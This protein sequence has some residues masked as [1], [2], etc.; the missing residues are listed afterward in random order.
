MKKKVNVNVTVIIEY[1]WM[2]LNK[3]DSKY[4]LGPKYAKMLNMEKFCT[5]QG[6]QYGNITQHSEYATVCL[7]RVLGIYRVLNI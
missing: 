3:H 1:V 5:W 7:D 4:A 2:C 6:S